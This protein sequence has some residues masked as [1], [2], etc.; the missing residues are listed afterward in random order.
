MIDIEKHYFNFK[1]MLYHPNA[2]SL[3]NKLCKSQYYSIDEQH[4]N[5]ENKLRKLVTFACNNIPFYEKFYKAHSFKLSDM[6]EEGWFE[7]LPIVTKNDIRNHFGDFVCPGQQKNLS[8]SSTGGSTGVPVQFG[9]DKRIPWEA[10]I[11]RMM[12]WWGI[13]PWDS[14]AYA[15]RMRRTSLLSITLNNIL[16]WPKKKICLDASSMNDSEI[17]TFIS[18]INKIHPKIL[19]GYVGALVEIAKFIEEKHIIIHSP[20]LVWSTAA[21]LSKI[22]KQ[23]LEKIF[24]APVFN[25]YGCCEV[26]A[27]AAECKEHNGLHVNVEKVKIEFV[28]DNSVTPVKTENWGRTLL[29]KL[30][31]YVFPLIRY[32]VG[33]RGRWLKHSCPCGITLPLIDQVKGRE[34]D[35]IRLPSGRLVNGEYLTTI[36]DHEPDLVNM[37]RIVQKK[38]FEIVL[39][40][41]PNRTTNLDKIELVRKNLEAKVKNEVPVTLKIVSSIPQDRGK[42]RFIVNEN[43]KI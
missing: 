35:T 26:P 25:Q 3:Y 11:W 5:E 39:E 34:S 17:L 41:V 27:L 13:H 32:E 18:Q 22:H 16:W 28:E 10:Y 9:I 7:K 42:I 4:S 1:Y 20:K 31:D 21:P 2:F 33:D 30:D 6:H 40:I 19:Q 12:D 15:W 38:D 8:I 14:G 29:T 36:F 24:K 37:F 43:S 23:L